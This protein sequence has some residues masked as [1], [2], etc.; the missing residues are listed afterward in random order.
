MKKN[1]GV[2]M[3]FE[4]NVLV[5]SSLL[6]FNYFLVVKGDCGLGNGAKTLRPFSSVP[7]KMNIKPASFLTSWGVFISSIILV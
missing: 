5:L 3:V 1:I 2:R 4:A 7:S 6:Y